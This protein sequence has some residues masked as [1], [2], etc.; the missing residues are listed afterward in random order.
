M[1]DTVSPASSVYLQLGDGLEIVKSRPKTKKTPNYYRVGNGTVNRN[2]IESIDLLRE[3]ANMSKPAQFL[4][5]A[6]KD[7]MSWVNGFSPV[8]RITQSELCATHQKYL[9]KGF[10]E[11]KEKDLVRRIRRSHYMVNPNALI[12]PDYEE[13][14]KV[15]EDADPNKVLD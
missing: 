14:L 2:K 12:P 7:G 8:V 10:K 11:L 13:A 1:D 5:L 6:I 9:K 3:I 4:V 15:W